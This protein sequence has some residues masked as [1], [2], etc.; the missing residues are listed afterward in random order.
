MTVIEVR[1]PISLTV[2]SIVPFDGQDELVKVA[3]AVAPW[4]MVPFTGVAATYRLAAHCEWAGIEGSFV[5]CGVWRGGSAAVLSLANMSHGTEAR[6]LHLFDAYDD[7]P[8]P[9]EAVDGARACAEYR[10]WGDVDGPL[11]AKLVPATGLYERAG[12]G[13]PGVASEVRDL[14]V[15]GLEH[16]ADKV[17]LH[18]GWVQDT[19]PVSDT[20][21]IALLR[22]DVDLFHPTRACLEGLYDRVVPG[23]F[24]IIDDYGAYEG[25]SSA[26]DGFL[27][28]RGERLFF[29]HIDA[30]RRYFVK[31]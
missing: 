17:H 21:P 12:L 2:P 26:V 22:L 5:E 14:L 8:E 9:D 31:P 18:V 27:A 1:N 10:A 28:E 19:V 6:D 25:C 13:G 30:E 24:V 15:E 16:P 20:G 7:P 23:G 11:E 4:T 3:Q 29:H